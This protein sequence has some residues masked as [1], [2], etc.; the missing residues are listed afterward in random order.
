MVVVVGMARSG[1]AASR[2]LRSRGCEVFATDSNPEPALKREFDGDGIPSE[3]GMHSLEVLETADEVVVSPGVP[4]EIGFLGAARQRG[5]SVVS[6]IEMAFRYLQG[7][8]VAITGSNG[9]TTTTALVGHVLGHG[10]RPVQIGGNIGTPVSDLVS[11]STEETINVIEVSSFQLDLTRTFRPR[12]GVLLNI[13]PDHLDRYSGFDAYRSSKQRL[14]ANQ[15]EQD[16]AV[17]NGDDPGVYPLPS[18]MR[19]RRME[20]STRGRPAADASLRDGQVVIGETPVMPIGDI[21]LRGM[22]NVENVLAALLAAE[23]CGFETGRMASAVGTFRP[24]AHRI[25]TVAS[26]DGVEFVNDSKATNVDS[27]VKA[28]ESFQ[29]PIVLIL[30]GQGKGSSYAPLVRAMSGRVRQAVTIGAAADAIEAAIGRAVPVRRARTMADAVEIAIG[31]AAPGDVVLLAPACASYDMYRN[32]EERGN[33]FKRS[34]RSHLIAR[35][36]EG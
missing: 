23:A 24:V 34:V 25:E 1:L 32:Y 20:F 2:L 30:G 36:T 11:S 18:C 19:P 31:V 26:I 17:L 6:E 3:T 35:S 10:P 21:P 4:M 9:K 14:F 16:Y 33:D 7:E 29:E 13:T 15:T 27:A 12:V 5:L 22:H 8:I 28:V